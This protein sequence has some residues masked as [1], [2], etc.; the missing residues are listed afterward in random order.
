MMLDQP[1]ALKTLVARVKR[2]LGV[3]QVQVATSDDSPGRIERVCLCAGAGGS[4]LATAIAQGA[5]MYLTGEMR[6]HDVLHAQASGVTVVLAGHTNTERGY[7]RVLKR[8]LQASHQDVE[9]IVSRRDT[10]PLRL[11]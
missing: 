1:V 6:H 5:Q 2:Q 11:M 9:M 10:E 7:L 4:L 8:R 3:E